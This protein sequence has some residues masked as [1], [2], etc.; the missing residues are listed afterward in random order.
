MFLSYAAFLANPELHGAIFKD[1]LALGGWK[2]DGTMRNV[3]WLAPHEARRDECH[4]G[5]PRIAGNVY[6]M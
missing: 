1:G 6:A 5:I 4:H 2:R 3:R